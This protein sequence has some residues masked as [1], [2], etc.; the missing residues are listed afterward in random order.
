LWENSDTPPSTIVRRAK[1]SLN[2]WQFMQRAIQPSQGTHKESKWLKPLPATMKCNVDC[3]LFNNNTITGYGL[4]FRDSTGQL[5]LGMSNY[6]FFSSSPTEAEALGL[7]EAI[8]LAAARGYHSVTFESDCRF[9]VDAVNTTQVP[10]N[11]VGDIISSCQELLS[12]H[13]HFYVKYVRRQANEV[14]HSIARASLS[15][16][17]PYIFNDVPSYLFPLIMNEMS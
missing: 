9:V 11:E 2:E 13:S 8:K 7:L 6:D 4:C 5:V 10:Q 12:F 15:H 1:D 16:P 3:A 17:R 14:A